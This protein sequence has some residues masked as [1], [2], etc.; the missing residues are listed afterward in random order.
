MWLHTD[1]QPLGLVLLTV[2]VGLTIY[3]GV[4]YVWKHRA[5]ISEM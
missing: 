2:A 3:S 4:G 5:Y 1:W